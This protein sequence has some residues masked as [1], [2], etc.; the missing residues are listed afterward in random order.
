MARCEKCLMDPC[1]CHIGGFGPEEDES[2]T[3]KDIKEIMNRR[4][5]VKITPEGNELIKKAMIDM[6]QKFIKDQKFINAI[7]EQL[8]NRLT[9]VTGKIDKIGVAQLNGVTMPIFLVA[10]DN[11]VSTD[12]PSH[13][14]FDEEVIYI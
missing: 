12:F 4:V 6:N 3:E 2:T 8:E 9:D 7:A 5:I 13:W 14:Y 10:Y 11:P 1:L